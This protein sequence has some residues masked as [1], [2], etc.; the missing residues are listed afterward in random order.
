MKPKTLLATILCMFV[1]Q[2]AT[3]QI[4]LTQDTI[5]CPIIGF[6]FGTTIPSN[7]LSSENG[8][9][10]LYKPPYLNFGLEA[11]YKTKTNYLFSVDG[12]LTIGGDNL[13]DR[14]IR[15][16][17]VYTHDASPIVAGTNG[18]DANVTCYNRG[19]TFRLGI[20]K[21]F[22]L[23][24]QNPNSGI[25]T[26]LFGG[27]MNQKTIF[28]MNDVNA[29]QLQGDYARLYDHSRFGGILTESIGFWYMSKDYNVVNIYVAF[30]LTQCWSHSTRDYVIDYQMGLQGPDNNKYFDLI[31]GLKICWMIPL[32]GKTAY[33]YHLLY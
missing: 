1:L 12:V 2:D 26:R 9:Y 4:K 3:A 23:N 30:E 25:V 10:D 22:T 6:T 13:R 19:L 5:S 7:N 18:T 14:N 33:D 16:G 29:P 32:K 24:D 31:Y 8:M 11:S 15:L 28:F 27:F 21:I 17:D 20:G